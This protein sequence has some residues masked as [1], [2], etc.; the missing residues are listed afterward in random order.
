MIRYPDIQKS[1][2]PLELLSRIAQKKAA[3]D[4][5]RPLPAVVAA[6]V[7]SEL[8]LEWTYH[9]NS[10][11]GNTLNLMETRVVLEQGLTIGGKTLKEHFEAINHHKAIA[12]LEHMVQQKTGMDVADILDLH[13]LVMQHVDDDFAGRIRNGY[14]RITGA[15]FQPPRPEW[16]S[17]LLDL[18]M[19]EH[20]AASF[21]NQLQQAAALHH[22]LVW[23]H[24]FFDGN[25]RTT[26][27]AMNLYLMQ[28]G[29]PPAIIQQQDRKKYYDALNLANRGDY[30]KL[31][32]LIGQALDRSL[33]VYLHS[34]PMSYPDSM[35]L[36]DLA[37][38]PEVPYGAEY[39]GLLARRGLID[40]QKE[41]RNWYSSVPAIKAYMKTNKKS[42][43]GV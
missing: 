15:N 28:E 32:L 21:D 4:A 12:H 16:C 39:L 11:E 2:A 22:R 10:I 26:R 43:A 8:A 7:A 38:E 30:R 3:L 33:Q 36:H 18:M 5:A 35:S 31:E 19:E 9:S 1:G 6:R 25:G 42:V 14:V 29:Y 24:P 34:L 20:A 17:E 40:A 41:G 13:R 23:I 37:E 27:L